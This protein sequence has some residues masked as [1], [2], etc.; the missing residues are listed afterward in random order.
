MATYTARDADRATRRFLA[1]QGI[2]ESGMALWPPQEWL[3]DGPNRWVHLG[4]EY[5][6]TG[7][8]ECVVELAIP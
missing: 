1:E 8:P 7:R 3:A 5:G 6:A 4:A 2:D